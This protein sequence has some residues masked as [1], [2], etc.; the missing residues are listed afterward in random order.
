MKITL[1]FKEPKAE[2]KLVANN[3]I[4]VFMSVTRQTK[5]KEAAINLLT[6]SCANNLTAYKSKFRQTRAATDLFR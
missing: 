2:V 4:F 5:T 6:Y 1:K 3:H